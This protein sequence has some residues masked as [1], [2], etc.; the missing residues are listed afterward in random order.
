[1][2]I[3]ISKILFYKLF[4]AFNILSLITLFGVKIV[5]LEDGA[6][7]IDEEYNLKYRRRHSGFEFNTNLIASAKVDNEFYK[8]TLDIVRPKNEDF[9]IAV[10]KHGSSIDFYQIDLKN[11]KV[12]SCRCGFRAEDFIKS[13]NYYD[14]NLEVLRNESNNNIYLK[15]GGSIVKFYQ[16]SFNSDSSPY[17]SDWFGK[18]D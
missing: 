17:T 9:A 16:A 8:K 13:S 15:F 1:M 4:F 5:E 11:L 2:T 3:N 14:F 10:V 12:R 7:L 6:L 18:I